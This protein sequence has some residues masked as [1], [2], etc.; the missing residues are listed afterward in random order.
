MLQKSSINCL[1][2]PKHEQPSFERTGKPLEPTRETLS[3]ETTCTLLVP[4]R[5]QPSFETTNKPLVQ[6]R[7]KP[8]F[9]ENSRLTP[10]SRIPSL[11]AQSHPLVPKSEISRFTTPSSPLV[12]KHEI[13]CV[14][15]PC[16]PLVPKREIPSF[17]TPSSP[18]APKREIPSFVSTS[19][20]LVPKRQIQ[21]FVIP[22]RYQGRHSN[23]SQMDKHV[24]KLTKNLKHEEQST[25][26]GCLINSNNFL[27]NLS[28]RSKSRNRVLVKVCDKKIHG[29]VDKDDFFYDPG[30]SPGMTLKHIPLTTSAY[31]FPTLDAPATWMIDEALFHKN[32]NN[33]A[34][35]RQRCNAFRS[36]KPKSRS[37]SH[38]GFIRSDNGNHTASA[39]DLRQRQSSPSIMRKKSSIAANDIAGCQYLNSSTGSGR[40]PSP[41]VYSNLKE[42]YKGCHLVNQ[43]RETHTIN[44]SC[45]IKEDGVIQVTIHSVCIPSNVS[46]NE[47][48]VCVWIGSHNR[49]HLRSRKFSKWMPSV[50]DKTNVLFGDNIEFRNPSN[51]ADKYLH[52]K[53]MSRQQGKRTCHRVGRVTVP[54]PNQ[55]KTLARST[56][57]LEATP[58]VCIDVNTCI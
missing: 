16:S 3:F 4:Q 39:P 15:T 5:E 10:K 13:P 19:Y 40:K 45:H 12:P 1:L 18:L 57:I 14:V 36:P 56:R 38:I 20:S 28:G 21:S 44:L 37:H 24:P 50:C 32:D 33:L 17:A 26:E 29:D 41:V 55:G 48:R 35:N 46:I 58:E 54:I 42:S 27:C 53:V 51:L 47:T 11:V 23:P 31:G 22:P 52:F 8:S 2:V 43:E 49:K 34:V 30:L 7:E 25:E 6:K 9:Q